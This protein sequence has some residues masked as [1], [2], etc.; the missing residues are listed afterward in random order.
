MQSWIYFVILSEFMWSVTSLL[1]KALLSKNYIKSPFVFII[2]NGLM[3]I[4]LIFLLPFF[5]FGKLGIVDISIALMSGIFLIIGLV[6]YYKAVQNEEISRVIMLW[7]FT[8]VFVLL[9]SFLFLNEKLSSN[10]LAGFVFLIAAG[11]VVGYKKINGKMILSKA[12]YYLVGAS[13]FISI[14]YVFSNHIYQVTNFWSAFMW[15]RLSALSSIFLLLIPSIRKEFFETWNA[16]RK[17]SRLTIS[18][19]MIID[20]SAFIILGLA[21]VSGPVALISALGSSL[22]PIIIF[23]LTTLTTL[24]LPNLIKEEINKKIVLIKLLAIALIIAGIIFINL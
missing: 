7:Q 3:N 22:A 17:N 19:K 24:Y 9:I 8:P 4:L 18:S 15:L 1:D 21:M 12:F 11:L 23:L 2:F 5:N 14:F 13:V 20:F 10:Y 16:M 6:F